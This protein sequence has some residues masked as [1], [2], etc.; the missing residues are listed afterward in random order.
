MGILLSC[1]ILL[2]SQLTSAAVKQKKTPIAHAN[3]YLGMKYR[4]D[5]AR[6]LS[7]T[8]T[9]FQNPALKFTTPG[10]NCSGLVLEL[11]RKI[12]NVPFTIAAAKFDRNSN[13]QK[14]SSLGEDWDF[15]LD[16]ILNLS[17]GLKRKIILP[18]KG[19]S[20]IKGRGFNLHLEENWHQVIKKFRKNHLYFATINKPYRKKN[21]KL[22]YYHVALILPEE[23]EHVW[24]YHSTQKSHV[25]RFDIG[26]EKGLERLLYQFSESSFGAK[27]ILIIEVPNNNAA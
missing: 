24:F 6:N 3:D 17:E 27:Y 2:L 21:Y 18:D 7:G 11:A 19:D 8:Y 13:S 1:F 20:K 14:N 16:L 10:L 15:G 26:T 12:R 5:G 25:H 22:I 4:K 9:T 23:D